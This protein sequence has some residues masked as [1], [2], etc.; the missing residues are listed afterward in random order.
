MKYSILLS[1]LFFT[2]SK[3][4]AQEKATFKVTTLKGVDVKANKSKIP[5]FSTF[6][7]KLFSSTKTHLSYTQGGDFNCPVAIK[8][9]NYHLKTRIDSI[10]IKCERLDIQHLNFAINIFSDSKLADRVNIAT[11]KQNGKEFT[12]T[13]AKETFL[14]FNV[15]YL[16]YAYSIENESNFNLY[17][18]Q[19]VSGYLYSY[20]KDRD[21]FKLLEEAGL[22]EIPVP[23]IE[24]YYTVLD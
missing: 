24:I 16:S 1:A 19:K 14:P 21:E 11:V 5:V 18:N 9:E 3:A 22:P 13:P 17:S 12:L 8:I 10:K 23:Q 4:R 6:T 7:K 20:N 2:I 15:S